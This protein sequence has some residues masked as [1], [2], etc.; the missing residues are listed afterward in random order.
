MGDYALKQLLILQRRLDTPL[1]QQW[2]QT[3]WQ[4]GLENHAIQAHSFDI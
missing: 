4:P 1:F 3:S 2:M